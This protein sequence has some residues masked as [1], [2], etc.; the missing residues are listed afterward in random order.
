MATTYTWHFKDVATHQIVQANSGLQQIRDYVVYQARPSLTL[1]KSESF[2]RVRD[3][4][5]W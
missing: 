5:A 3:G 2:L 4:L 1:Q